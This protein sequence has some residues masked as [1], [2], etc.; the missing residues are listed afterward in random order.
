[1][2]GTIEMS[3]KEL[4]RF[5][6]LQQVQLK[7][8]TQVAAAK[9][10][11]ISERQVRNLLRK[12]EKYGVESLISKKRGFPSN[13]Q[14]PLKVKALVMK[15]MKSK[16]T[17]FG[18]T[19]AAEKLA[20]LEGIHVSAETLRLWMIRGNLWLHRLQ[21]KKKKHLPRDRRECF[22]ELIQVDGSHHR[23]FGDDN[24]KANLIVF[25]DDATSKLT[26]LHFSPTETLD[27]YFTTLEGHLKKYGRPRAI[28]SD[29][30]S[31]FSSNHGNLHKPTQMQRA[32]KELDVE[33][34]L[35]N[36]PQAKGRVERANRTLQDRLL[37]ELKLRGITSLEEANKF[38]EEF[39]KT[40]ND[41]FSKEPAKSFNSHRP[42]EG[43]DLDKTL[44]M[45]EIRTLK[46]D[47]TFQFN[48]KFYQ[49]QGIGELRRVKGRKIEV[50]L[51]KKGKMRVFMGP[52]EVKF[53]PLDEIYEKPK[54]Y[55]KK[56]VNQW[57]PKAKKAPSKRH[58]WKMYGYQ[59]PVGNHLKKIGGI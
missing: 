49:V 41:K 13:N 57:K 43:R 6:I 37:K 9:I 39:I 58:P 33:L 20:E 26:G 17:G 22:G 44:S 40:Y 24:P 55:S 28:Y 36:S 15:L 38:T 34:I 30:C 2:E 59:I 48:N 1:M 16:Y 14:K 27:A 10:L 4:D 8:L 31:V 21:R 46:C 11:G 51:T 42:L 53:L 7:Q 3:E 23:W 35:A 25:V 18:P 54:S 32:L 47:C 29:K 19:F 12:F 56:E 50:R 5:N 45:Q 52:Q